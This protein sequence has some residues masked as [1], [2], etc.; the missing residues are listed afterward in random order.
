M[1][2]NLVKFLELLIPSIHQERFL[3]HWAELYVKRAQ[4]V[5]DQYPMV[6]ATYRLA[7]A[8][9]SPLH[10]VAKDKVHPRLVDIV[11]R[12]VV[13]TTAQIAQFEGE[14]LSSC[15]EFLLKIPARYVEFEAMSLAIRVSLS[16]GVR[17]THAF[18]LLEQYLALGDQSLYTATSCL[19]PLVNK[20]LVILTHFFISSLVTK[21]SITPPNACV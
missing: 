12:F 6:S 20:F 11:R 19:L 7:K 1:Y 10:I 18:N 8:C 3:S 21:F 9:L 15:L 16:S 17:C 2:I 13:S 4:V 5:A 14:L